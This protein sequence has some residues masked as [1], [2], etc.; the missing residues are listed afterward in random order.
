MKPRQRSLLCLLGG[1][2]IP[3]SGFCQADAAGKPLTCN[4]RTFVKKSPLR[5]EQQG[6]IAEQAQSLKTAVGSCRSLNIDRADLL[7]PAAGRPLENGI[8]SEP[9]VRFSGK[10]DLFNSMVVF[11]GFAQWL[12]DLVF[13]ELAPLVG[14]GAKQ[15]VEPWND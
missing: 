7:R 15:V 1:R 8:G 4:L 13:D 11:E 14:N 5:A 9:R 12:I 10:S 3:S 6:K 2:D